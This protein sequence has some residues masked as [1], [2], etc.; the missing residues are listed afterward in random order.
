MFDAKGLFS[1]NYGT[2]LQVKKLELVVPFA[3]RAPA[4]ILFLISWRLY[5]DMHNNRLFLS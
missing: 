2:M 3:L 5:E 1:I 4:A